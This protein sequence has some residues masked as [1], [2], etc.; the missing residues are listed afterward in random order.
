MS[1]VSIVRAILANHAPLLALVPKE[2]IIAGQVQQ[3]TALPAV[4]IAEVSNYVKD[5]S[6]RRLRR[7]ELVVSRVQVTV[8]AANYASLKAILLACKGSPGMH[9]GIINGYQVNSAVPVSVGP[10]MPVGDDKIY[11]QSR[12]FVVT[13]AEPI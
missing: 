4:S 2:R 13:F 12:D 8:L 9:T 5:T 3:G 11:E 1:G 7:S 10:E 6:V